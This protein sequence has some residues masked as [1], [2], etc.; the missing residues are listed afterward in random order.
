MVGGPR[1]GGARVGGGGGPFGDTVTNHRYNLTV[2][3]SAHNAFN[4]ENLAPPVGILSSPLFG[5]SN[6]LAGGFF[7]SATANRRIEL[8]CRFSF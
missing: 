8:Q 6:A 1:G 5:V 3:V 4:R 2:G 7:G